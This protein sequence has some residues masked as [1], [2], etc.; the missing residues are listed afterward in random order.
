MFFKL[1]VFKCAAKLWI[2]FTLLNR[3]F[4]GGNEMETKVRYIYDLFFVSSSF[5]SSKAHQFHVN[6]LSLG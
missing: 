2:L 3:I 1:R 5:Y 6:V 4:A